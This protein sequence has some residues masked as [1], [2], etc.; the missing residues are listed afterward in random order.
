[1][2][3]DLTPNM[4]SKNKIL[5]NYRGVN[6]REYPCLVLRITVPEMKKI[7][8]LKLDFGMTAKE[9]IESKKVL[10]R[11]CNKIEVVSYKPIK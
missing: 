11:D 2:R 7:V 4:F 1:M 9:A 6:I 5:E 8:D 3:K 10:C